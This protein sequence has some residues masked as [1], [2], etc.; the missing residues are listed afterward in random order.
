M[1]IKIFWEKYNLYLQILCKRIS[2]YQISTGTG[3][4]SNR[5]DNVEPYEDDKEVFEPDPKLK[6]T[7]NNSKKFSQQP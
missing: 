2:T 5:K 7:A 4:P 3:A 1:D 6:V